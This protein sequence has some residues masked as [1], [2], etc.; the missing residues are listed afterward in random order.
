[1]ND[2]S[3]GANC[4]V[5]PRQIKD[6]EE[7]LM[8]INQIRTAKTGFVNYMES[9]LFFDEACQCLINAINLFQYGYF[10]AAFYMLRQSIETSIGT[11][12]LVSNKDK[13][14]NWENLERGFEQGKMAEWLRNNEK[15]FYEMKELMPDFFQRIRD[16]QE[17]MNKYVHKQGYQS[18]YTIVRNKKDEESWLNNTQCE[19]ERILCDSIGAVTVY[20]LAID[21]FPVALAE[22]DLALRSPDLITEGLSI[23]FLEKYI[24]KDSIEGYKQTQIYKDTVDWL[25]SLPKQSEPVYY[26]I[27]YQIVNRKFHD[28]YVKQWNLLGFDDRLALQ[29]FF[30]CKKVCR[31]YVNGFIAYS[32]DTNS[33]NSEI[34]IGVSYFKEI[35]SNSPSENNLKYKKSYLSRIKIGNDYTYLEH[36][37][38]L[39]SDEIKQY[40]NYV[41]NLLSKK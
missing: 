8:A 27:H 6:V 12:Y 2:F 16:D 28:D 5:K 3:I 13:I 32:S 20:R 7:Y 40:N 41:L 26:L 4:W 15:S 34:V 37:E 18:F 23:D 21:A 29:L 31:I 10:D 30:I 36:N 24:G 17:T 35:F 19:F 22:E 1:M 14:K 39:T 33:L 11:L 9:N 25:N 38:E